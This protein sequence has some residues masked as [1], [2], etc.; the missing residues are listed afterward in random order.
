[1]LYAIAFLLELVAWTACAASVFLVSGGWLAWVLAVVVF[2][3]VIALWGA[4][5]APRA[6]WPLPT[7]L[8]YLIKAG[9]YGFAAVVLW[10]FAPWAG[11]GFSASVLVSEPLLYRYRGDGVGATGD[12]VSPGAG[13]DA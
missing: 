4:V 9:I 6:R 7:P 3:L 12:P 13:P 5:M 1:M 10:L 2:A 11:V 8:Y